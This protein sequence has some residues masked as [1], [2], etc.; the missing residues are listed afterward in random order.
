MSG[1]SA[2]HAALVAQ[3]A[4]QIGEDHT[5]SGN[6][7]VYTDSN[8]NDFDRPQRINGYLPDVF[9]HDVPRTFSVIGEAKTPKDLTTERSRQQLVGFLDWLSVF[10]GSIFYLAV[11]PFAE[12]I[13]RAV[14][15]R[16][17]RDPHK[18]VEIVVLELQGTY[19]C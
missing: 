16:V 19:D 13:A 15:T 17:I 10:N 11:P 7:V 9:A 5:K 18:S 2:L 4:T 8:E 14:L 1:E 3:L 12:P 6:M